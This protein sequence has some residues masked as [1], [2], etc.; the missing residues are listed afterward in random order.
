MK[1]YTTADIAAMVGLSM[2]MVRQVA[3]DRN[4][5]T[6]INATTR[7]YQQKDLTKFARRRRPKVS[8][9]QADLV[10]EVTRKYGMY[11]SG[12]GQIYLGPK[13][14]PL[15]HS[16]GMFAPYQGVDDDILNALIKHYQANPDD[17]APLAEL[18]LGR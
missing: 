11:L 13:R 12:T 9:K 6:L 17:P 10:R 2:R 5:G 14:A 8:R 18:P 15:D 4:I 3:K 16:L 1:T 7:V